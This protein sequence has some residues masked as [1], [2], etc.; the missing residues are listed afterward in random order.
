MRILRDIGNE[1]LPDLRSV[2]PA[3]GLVLR[4]STLPPHCLR[5]TEGREKASGEGKRLVEERWKGIPRKTRDPADG[6]RPP[7]NR[8]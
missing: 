5:G 1:E 7:E 3:K 8:E 4:R 2:F 6:E